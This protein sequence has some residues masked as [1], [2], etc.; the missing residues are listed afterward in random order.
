MTLFLGT[1]LQGLVTGC[2]IAL[3][4]TGVTLVYR[5]VRV[6]NFAQG[7]L[8]TL[9]TYVY[10][11]FVAIWGWPALFALPVALL[12]AAGVGVAAE[13]V[14][15]RPLEGAD[16]TS[17]A[18]ATIGLVLVIQWIVLSVWGAQQRFLPSLSSRGVSFGGVRLGAQH[19][20][21]AMTAI[22]LGIALSLVLGRTRAGLALAA[23]ADDAEAARVLG[24]S[25]RRV[26]RATFVLASLCGALAGILATPLLVLT[27]SQMTLVFVVALGASLAGGFES[28]GRT[29]IA[30]L[31]LGV[32]QSLATSYAPG[33][34]G[35]PQASGLL[36]VL[37]ILAFMRR[38]GN[39]V[40]LTRGHA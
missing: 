28:L 22:A 3:L 39:L 5:S 1:L 29:V 33:I 20:I 38:R 40:D 35:L 25:P 23:S 13:F 19:L 37:A 31:V 36:A 9:N 24:V 27:P 21:I 34:S 17:R 8:A 2:I 6:L 14:A 16:R 11:Q 32:L 12:F 4:A 30:G 18:A 26:S 7:S 10:Y 15:V